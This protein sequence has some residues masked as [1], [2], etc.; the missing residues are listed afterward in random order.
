MSRKINIT[1][2]KSMLGIMSPEAVALM[3]HLLF[4]AQENDGIMGPRGS[5]KTSVKLLA[6]VT[7]ISEWKLRKALEELIKMN[8]ITVETTNRYTVISIV[9]YDKYVGTKGQKKDTLTSKTHSITDCASIDCKG[10]NFKPHEQTSSKPRA[11]HEQNTS[12]SQAEYENEF[13][14]NC[15]STGCENDSSEDVVESVIEI[16]PEIELK[17]NQ[18]CDSKEKE[19]K[20]SNIKKENKE[21]EIF[22]EKESIS[23]EIQKKENEII[24]DLQNESASHR[25]RDSGLDYSIVAESLLDKMME[26]VDMRKRI[27]KPIRT[28]RA[29]R[30]RYNKAIRLADGDLELAWRLID[31]SISH[32]WQDIYA[33]KEDKQETTITG[34]SDKDIWGTN[35]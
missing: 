17:L 27:R 10:E 4:G 16:E 1:P 22:L 32:E 24:C 5:M 33:L 6:G 18:K 8:Y 9:D 29:F 30:D 3:V 31:Q 11:K 25:C 14:N 20:K 21:K 2:L 7:S 35:N 26:Y 28:Q 12:K 23:K 34:Y 19:K 13:A 15:L